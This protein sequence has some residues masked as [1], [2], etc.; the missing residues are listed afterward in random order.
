MTV[1][2]RVMTIPTQISIEDKLIL[3]YIYRVVNT[4][5]SNIKPRNN[6]IPAIGI[7]FFLL[8]IKYIRLFY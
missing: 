7:L 6:W 4:V 5:E 2:L 8:V 1:D 3:F